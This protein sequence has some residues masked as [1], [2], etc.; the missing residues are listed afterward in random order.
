MMFVNFGQTHSRITKKPCCRACC[1]RPWCR[2]QPQTKTILYCLDVIV[3]AVLRN[4][5]QCIRRAPQDSHRWGQVGRCFPGCLELLWLALGCSGLLWTAV[6]CPGLLWAALRCFG[7]PWT[8]SDW[9]GLLWEA[10]GCFG[11]LWA[12]LGCSGFSLS[13]QGF[14]PCPWG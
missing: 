5:S 4:A 8:A 1:D 6:G 10:L 3:T 7:L 12:S 2:D 13:G 11:L 14:S 9:V